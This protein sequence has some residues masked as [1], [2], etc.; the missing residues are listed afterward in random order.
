MASSSSKAKEFIQ[1]KQS[2]Y[3]GRSKVKLRDDDI[4]RCDCRDQPGRHI[5]VD[6][7]CVN[8]STH[9][10]CVDCSDKRCCNRRIQSGKWAEVEEIK[11]NASFAREPTP[12]VAQQAG[13]RV[14]FPGCCWSCGLD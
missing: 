2:V 11:V 10:E 3:V 14:P 9:V 12:V 8:R 1:I 13:G 5:C 6:N 7:D 4:Q